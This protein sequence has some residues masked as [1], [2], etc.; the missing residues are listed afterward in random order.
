MARNFVS[1]KDEC[2]RMFKSDFLETFTR[3]HYS[4]PLIIFLPVIFYFT[5]QALVI[6]DLGMTPILLLIGSGIFF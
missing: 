5:Y 6:Y 3:V 2:V 1:N 4:V